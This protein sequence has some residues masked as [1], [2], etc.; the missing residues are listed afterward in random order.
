MPSRRMRF[1]GLVVALLVVVPLACNDDAGSNGDSQATGEIA[2]RPTTT[3][4]VADPVGTYAVGERFGR[5]VDPSRSTPANGSFPGAPDRTLR[6][7]ILYPATGAPGGTIELE[8]PPATA[9]GPFPL[10]VFSH[11]FRGNGGAYRV[12]A[13]EWASAGYVVALPDY[14]LSNTDAP[15]GPVITDVF[16]QPADVSFVLDS[17]VA[18]AAPGGSLEGL[19]DGERLGAAGH[20]LGGITTYGVT[21]S[22]CCADERIDAAIAISGIAGVVEA[23]ENYFA[24]ANAPLLILHGDDDEI[25]GYEHAT[26]AFA[27]APPPKFLVT[28]LGAGHGAP[29]HGG[30]EPGAP[31]VYAV[32]IAFLDFYLKDDPEGLDRLRSAV[33]AEPDV[34]TLQEQVA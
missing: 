20:S 5:F 4:A 21:A 9:G 34:A 1:G 33:S 10:V 14:P 13:G 15:G 26:N 8:T 25:V 30:D 24:G 22:A 23:E 12:L 27:R 28:F 32:T 7:R 31:T 2:D 18:L 11:G 16:Q 17:V 19:V 29:F 3:V 6:T